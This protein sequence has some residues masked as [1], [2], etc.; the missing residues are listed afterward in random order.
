MVYGV[1]SLVLRAGD[2]SVCCVL[3]EEGVQGHEQLYA[4]YSREHYSRGAS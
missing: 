1:I 2:G 4:G 3:S